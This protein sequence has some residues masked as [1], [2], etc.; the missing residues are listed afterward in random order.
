MAVTALE[1]L[2]RRYPDR[3]ADSVGPLL[4]K[5][6]GTFSHSLGRFATAG[7]TGGPL[8][9]LYL[10]LL[11]D[12]ERVVDFDSEVSNGARELRVTQS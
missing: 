12:F 1:E 2:Q 8:T 7:D 5:R 6:H 3:F 9:S 10:R 11:C 4:P